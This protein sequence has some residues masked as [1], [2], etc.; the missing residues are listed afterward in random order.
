VSVVCPQGH[1]SATTD[2][3]DQCGTPIEAEPTPPPQ[4]V[5]LESVEEEA[6]T[7]AAALEEPCP[8]CQRPHSESDRF[9]EDCG[10]DF[11]APPKA[12]TGWEAIVTADRGQFERFGQT[13]L[14]FPADYPERRVELDAPQVTIGRARQGEPEPEIDLSL[15]PEDPGV[16]RRHAMLERQDN[17]SYAVRDL[18]STNGTFINNGSEELEPD[19]KVE[20]DDGDRVRVGAWTTITVRAR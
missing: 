1:S 8:S 17:G 15:A 13:G 5:D 7:S 18:G 20:L 19:A 12:A 4:T 16:S 3:C 14:S 2:Y 10:Y 11:L 9:C 6:D